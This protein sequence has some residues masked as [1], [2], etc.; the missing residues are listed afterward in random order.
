MT[1]TWQ[2]VTE[3]SKSSRRPNQRMIIKGKK[4]NSPISKMRKIRM[5]MVMMKASVTTKMKE[6]RMEMRFH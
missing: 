5:L 2:R 4:R 3:I 1:K 6:K